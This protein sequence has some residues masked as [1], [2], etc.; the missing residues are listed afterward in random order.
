MMEFLN[1]APDILSIG[2]EQVPEH[3]KGRTLIDRKSVV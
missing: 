1:T 2:Q 3:L